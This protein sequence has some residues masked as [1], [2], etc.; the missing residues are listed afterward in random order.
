MRGIGKREGGRGKRGFGRGV[1]VGVLMLAV[2]LEVGAQERYVEL[3]Q[4]Y[5]RARLYHEAFAVPGASRP[6]LVVSF[7]IPNAMLVFVQARPG[8]TGGAFVAEAEVA[9]AVYRGEALVEEKRWRATQHA[10]DF[11]AT[12]SRTSDVEGLVTFALAPGLYTYRLT[13][14]DGNSERSRELKRYPV[15]VPD[16]GVGGVGGPVVAWDVQAAGP[17]VHLSLVNLGGDVPFGRTSEV[18]VPLSLPPDVR[19]GAATLTYAL[20]EREEEDGRPGEAAPVRRTR[21]GT[22][23]PPLEVVRQG[24]VVATGTVEGAALAPVAA[25]DASEQEGGALAWPAASAPV[26]YFARIPL[27]GERLTEGAYVL[28]AVLHVG[29]AESEPVARRRAPFDVRWHG[30]P[31][32]LYSPAVAIRN[33]QFIEARAV[34]RE[35]LKGGRSAQQA[36]LDAYWEARDPT[37][38][39]RANELMAEYYRRVDH[40]AD[41]FR[42]GTVPAPDGLA[43]DRARV[44]VV[45]GPPR[46]VRRTFPSPGGVEETWT[47]ADGRQ[48]VFRAATSFD[49]FELARSE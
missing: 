36:K 1:L 41:A 23:L 30:K 3:A 19:P 43:T 22:V 33:L 2:P 27:G 5:D 10:A 35:M 34:V 38:E 45:H 20:Y 44:Y 16:F 31:V 49:A 46:T 32:S 48:F 4:R 7:R 26:G 37:P 25:L 13:I 17:D 12:Q 6:A 47:Y 11:E 39:T 42:T 15:E 18:A 21:D 14:Q 28:E 24:A 9:V 40:A 29:D 8:E